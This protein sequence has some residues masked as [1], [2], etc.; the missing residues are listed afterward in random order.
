MSR[1]VD[2][3]MMF[4]D[5][6]DGIQS[7]GP[8]DGLSV[9]SMDVDEELDDG[10]DL[11]E[12]TATNALAY[13]RVVAFEQEPQQTAARRPRMV[14][15]EDMSSFRNTTTSKEGNPTPYD[16][17]RLLVKNKQ[18]GVKRSTE[19]HSVIEDDD[20]K[21]IPF[22]RALKRRR[23]A[24]PSLLHR[25]CS[26]RNLSLESVQCIQGILRVDPGAASRQH[27]LF[28]EEKVY[29]YLSHRLEAKKVR[30]SYTYPIN[31]A[32]EKDANTTVVKALI[33]A[34]KSVLARKDGVEQE[35]SLHILLKH[36][37]SNT[38][39]VDAI[40]VANPSAAMVED[41][42]FN[43]PLHVACRSG[44]SLDVIR[45]LWILYPEA[46]AK[47]NFN[48]LTP[49]DLARNNGHMC[50][51]GVASFLWQKVQDTDRMV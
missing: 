21:P 15:M 37:R 17:L 30:A 38:D 1:F 34:D 49:L 35:G 45:H 4:E 8:D 27:A 42:H 3:D 11:P 16:S 36:Q 7:V 12:Q 29:N 39:T 20:S 10:F 41:R 23:V 5:A 18:Q 33:D 28:T 47:Q 25:A 24:D 19:G 46:L 48:G 14:S 32:L 43:T 6:C 50:S 40:L 51:D 2:K 26:S 9:G 13:T 44:A 22:L 31:M